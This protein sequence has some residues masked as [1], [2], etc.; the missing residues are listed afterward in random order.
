VPAGVVV[1]EEIPLPPPP[2]AAANSITSD[3]A[4]TKPST[5]GNFLRFPERGRKIRP[6]LPIQFRDPL[7]S[8]YAFDAF[9]WD[10]SM[11]ASA[12]RN[13]MIALIAATASAGCIARF[14]FLR[15]PVGGALVFAGVFVLTAALTLTRWI[16]YRDRL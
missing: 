13:Y 5:P 11:P 6:L 10:I 3:I 8:R 9:V 16:K 15:G 14:M 12:R 7:T 4:H 2:H 1:D